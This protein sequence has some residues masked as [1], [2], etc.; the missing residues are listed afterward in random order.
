MAKIKISNEIT[1]FFWSELHGARLYLPYCN[2]KLQAVDSKRRRRRLRPQCV[3][4]GALSTFKRITIR[5]GLAEVLNWKRFHYVSSTCNYY[6]FIYLIW[7][8]V[9]EI[10]VVLASVSHQCVVGRTFQRRCYVHGLSA[11]KTRSCW[12]EQCRSL[13]STPHSD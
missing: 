7:C 9:L 5:S 8:N 10:C 6:T 4:A 11:L 1:I 12:D 2:A 13:L 3:W